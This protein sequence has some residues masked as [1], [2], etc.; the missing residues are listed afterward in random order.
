[1]LVMVID[2]DEE[3]DVCP[4]EPPKTG[5][6]KFEV[7]DSFTKKKRYRV[8]SLSE[9]QNAKSIASNIGV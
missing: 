3:S 4:Y 7:V 2:A 5:I 1:M 9:A 8:L 6:L